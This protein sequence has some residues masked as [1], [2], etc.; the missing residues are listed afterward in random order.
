M[1][2]YWLGLYD[3]VHLH[4]GQYIK[5][6]SRVISQTLVSQKAAVALA[7]S[8]RRAELICKL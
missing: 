4:V 8:I 3:C 7:A 1:K 6:F 2:Q 5:D